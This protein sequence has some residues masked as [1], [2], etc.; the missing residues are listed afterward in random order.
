V[1]LFEDENQTVKFGKEGR[2]VKTEKFWL[3]L[4]SFV[5]NQN[6]GGP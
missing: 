3:V 2:E 4:R 6:E 5:L 1:V